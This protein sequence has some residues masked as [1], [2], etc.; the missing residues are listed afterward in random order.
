MA[1]FDGNN[2]PICDSQ[3]PISRIASCMD[4]S[5]IPDDG[6]LSSDAISIAKILG[7]DKELVDRAETFIKLPN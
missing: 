6:K 4:Y 5:L 7:L 1:G 2:P 3:N